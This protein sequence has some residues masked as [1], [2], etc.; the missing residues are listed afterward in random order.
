MKVILGKGQ[1]MG[2]ISGAD[3]TLV[4]YAT[5]LHLAGHDVSVLL[6]Y[7]HSTQ[8]QYYQRLLK[9]G[10]PV[11]SI[12]PTSVHTSLNTGRKLAL[13]FLQ[14]FPTSRHLVRR[15]AQQIATS[16]AERYFEQ[17]R[18]FLR[19]SEADLIH[20]ITPDPSAMVLIRAA[21]SAGIP[22]LYQE[23][24][25]PFHPPDF[26]SYYEQFTS[27]LPMCSEVAALSPHLAEDCREKL[28]TANRLSVLPIMTDELFN[29]AGPQRPDT[30][31]RAGVTF[32]F[33]AR[34]EPLKGPLVL[35]EAFAEAA[36]RGS[37]K[38]RLRIAGAGSQRQKA[39]QRAEALGIEELCDFAGVYTETQEKS[40]F[41]R[42]LD[43]FVLPSLTEG[44][45][46][47]IIEA[48][49]HGLPVVATSV[50]GIPDVV[51]RETGI[52]VPPEDT[53][54]LAEAIRVLAA[55]PA[56]R[57]QMGRAAKERYEKLFSPASVLPLMLSTYQ[58]VIARSANPS[59]TLSAST[60]G[61][62]HPWARN[63]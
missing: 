24:G 34:L 61:L 63:S 6:M 22:V 45:P 15:K 48:M 32:G 41:M 13:G 56:L 29:G 21:H 11:S 43:V 38:I 30:K 27:V 49:A 19:R 37:E 8:D 10:V 17:C 3:E 52:L 4:A 44:T 18:D 54:A 36:S 1:F 47:S 50:G 39:T 55:D 5:Q 60:N 40:A 35:I 59:S 46:N 33:A 9:A 53:E 62:T 51:T 7:P 14:V 26:E 28:P 25:T 57:A 23:L 58:R 12:A 16:V 2:P 42:S 31:E 20:V